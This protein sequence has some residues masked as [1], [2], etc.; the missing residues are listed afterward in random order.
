M[1][2]SRMQSTIMEKN[3][4]RVTSVQRF[5]GLSLMLLI[6]IRSGIAKEA[7]GIGFVP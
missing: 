3:G 4:K 1:K 6:G 7:F 2:V 5:K